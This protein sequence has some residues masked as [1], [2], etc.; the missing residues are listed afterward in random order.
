MR[1]SQVLLVHCLIPF[2]YFC[3][4]CLE[5]NKTYVMKANN[6]DDCPLGLQSYEITHQINVHAVFFFF[7][8]F[9]FFCF[10]FFFVFVQ[11][12]V[13]HNFDDFNNSKSIIEL[14]KCCKTGRISFLLH[15][16]I[17]K[18]ITRFENGSYMVYYL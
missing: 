12:I 1:D 7:F 10:F 5:K 17:S 4:K 6:C 18:N 11:K 13:V 2:K 3:F 16:F 15:L 9:F 14:L 8:V